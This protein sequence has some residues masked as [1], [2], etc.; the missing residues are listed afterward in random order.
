M[1]T[2]K[3]WRF[4]K[5]SNSTARPS[6]EG[7][8]YQ[9]D[10]MDGSGI[11][12]PSALLD[13]G[14]GNPTTYNYAYIPEFSRY[15]YIRDWQYS[16]GLWLCSLAVDVLAT[17][18]GEIGGYNTFI[19]ISSFDTSKRFPDNRYQ[20]ASSPTIKNVMVQSPFTATIANGCFIM[21]IVGTPYG[22]TSPTTN[23]YA[24]DNDSMQLF[25][26]KLFNSP[27]WLNIT[28]VTT[29]LQKA[30]FNP[31]QYIS[32]C[33][34]FPFALST[35]TNKNPATKIKMG[36]WEFAGFQNTNTYRL[37]GKPHVE[38]G[39]ILTLPKHPDSAR[40]EFLNLAPHT[41]YQLQ[42]WP[43]GQFQLDTTQCYNFQSLQLAQTIDLIDG[44][45][46][47]QVSGYTDNGATHF[48]GY[49]AQIG[50]PIA[51]AQAGTNIVS[52]L[53]SG[54][55]TTA[56]KIASGDIIG[57]GKG[58]V[59]GVLDAVVP[60]SQIIGTNGGFNTY[61][62]NI[63]LTAQFFRPAPENSTIFGNITNVNGQIS[64]Y[65]GY[66]EAEAGAFSL[67]GTDAEQAEVRR[68]IQSGFYYE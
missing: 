40:G 43:Y 12:N 30:L 67:P 13:F 64:S 16:A 50:V 49:L 8:S 22:E 57:A 62:L 10:L 59:D 58:I 5:R 11:I 1:Y 15:Y 52:S 60:S 48:N 3:L 20:H 63:I 26:N 28:D 47:L 61:N 65:P 34:W 45:G 51:L 44:R 68:F 39:T 36:W 37:A 2:I 21:A 14:E 6:E 29:E 35:I 33:F 19:R 27:D 23:Y 7:A 55:I 32:S 46:F 4:A 17:W 54:A 18:R 38:F 24:L 9:C 31:I 56:G 42:Y 41:K 25:V 66:I 53:I